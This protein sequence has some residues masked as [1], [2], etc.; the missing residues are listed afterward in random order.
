VP[1]MWDELGPASKLA[2]AGNADQVVFQSQSSSSSWSR[3]RSL[4][5]L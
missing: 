4:R 2:A 5:F 1:N 3:A